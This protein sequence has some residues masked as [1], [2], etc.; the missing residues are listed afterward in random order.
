MVRI[1]DR[2]KGERRGSDAEE[3]PPEEE[4]RTQEDR[5]A[6]NRRSEERILASL[7]VDYKSEETFLFAYATNISTLGIFV[8]TDA[9]EPPGTVLDLTFPSPTGGG[10][11]FNVKGE[12]AWINPYREG[13]ENLNPGMG[14]KFI[15]VNKQ[16]RERII[17]LVRKI[18]YLGDQQQGSS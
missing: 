5:R 18:A 15:D 14:I 11:L 17:Q 10:S 7:R 6:V 1:S 2:R 4:R 13:E 9:P 16:T 8:R 3:R 12:V